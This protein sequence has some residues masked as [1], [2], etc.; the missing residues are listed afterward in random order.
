MHALNENLASVESEEFVD[1]IKITLHVGRRAPNVDSYRDD[2]VIAMPPLL[3]REV[4]EVALLT[5][6]NGRLIVDGAL[7]T[8]MTRSQSLLSFLRRVWNRRNL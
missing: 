8:E 2:I 3:V 6:L 7:K 4:T 5:P 1:K